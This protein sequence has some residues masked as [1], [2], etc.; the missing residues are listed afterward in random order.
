MGCFF[1]CSLQD[2]KCAFSQW[3]RPI[4]SNAAK[5]TSANGGSKVR[6]VATSPHFVS[7]LILCR[8]AVGPN[9]AQVVESWTN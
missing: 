1:S 5:V 4:P 6:P 9:T 8:K 3:A 7:L 2:S